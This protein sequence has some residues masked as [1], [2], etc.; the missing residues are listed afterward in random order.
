M[1][2]ASNSLGLRTAVFLGGPGVD[3]GVN[4]PREPSSTWQQA[5]VVGRVEPTGCGV[6][7]AIAPGPLLEHVAQLGTDD[8]ILRLDWA[9]IE[10]ECGSFDQAEL[11]RC[12]ALVHAL[13]RNGHGV[14]IVLSDGTAPAWFG[15][16]G[17]LMPAGPEY[18]ARYAGA[19][20]DHLA[21]DLGFVITL[22]E[23]SL[24][25]SAGWL[26]GAA[27]PFRWLAVRDAVAALD[28]LM[29]AHLLA[30]EEITNRREALDV[31]VVARLNQ[32]LPLEKIALGAAPDPA[33][34]DW[35]HRV[36]S[37]LQRWSPGR[38]SLLASKGS[39][40]G[41]AR[42]VLSVGWAPISFPSWRSNLVGHKVVGPSAP[43][44]ESLIQQALIAASREADGEAL[45]V[46]L[47]HR[48]STIDEHG[49]GRN[50][51]GHHRQHQ[52]ETV[53]AALVAASSSGVTVR[54]LV[55]GELVDRWRWG[56]YANREGLIGVDRA[57]GRRGYRLLET[58]AAS[59]KALEA[60]KATIAALASR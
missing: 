35:E 16:E 56:S 4:G 26:A 10:P 60:T 30:V 31:D 47:R 36:T 6:D 40:N 43:L 19:V 49:R 12:A 34:S 24:W 55:V 37:A 1:V 39:G 22:E 23:P 18:F 15:V 44:T 46:V 28:G 32:A 25:A 45:T 20:V 58:D 5:E 14:G 21:S 8:V 13:A 41:V 29:A 38:A 3:G 27:P 53:A 7:F 11:D 50:L 33:A 2:G 59:I 48:C 51:S 9:R 17:W 54:R 42:R 52:I 57:R